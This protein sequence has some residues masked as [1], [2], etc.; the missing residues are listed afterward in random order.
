MSGL[1]K[2]VG[3]VALGVIVY[4]LAVRFFGNQLAGGVGGVGTFLL[5]MK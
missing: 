3:S 1:A 4:V 5:C 2:F